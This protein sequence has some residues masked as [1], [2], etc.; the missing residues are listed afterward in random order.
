MTKF[1]RSQ[2]YKDQKHI[3]PVHIYKLLKTIILLKN[4]VELVN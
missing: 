1:K 3:K 4:A 2:F